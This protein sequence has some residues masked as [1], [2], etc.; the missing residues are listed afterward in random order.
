MEGGAIATDTPTAEILEY[1]AE[2]PPQTGHGALQYARALKATGGAEE[3]AKGQVI[4]A[5]ISM[6]LSTSEEAAFKSDWRTTIR[7]HHWDRLDMLLWRG[8]AKQ[9]ARMVPLV[10]GADHQKLAEARIGL[11]RKANG[12]DA[13]IAKVPATLKDDPGLAMSA[14][15]GVLQGG[16]Q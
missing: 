15:Y 7:D 1:F 14:S 8:E 12:V 6:S 16:A 3:E 9:A 13:L 5:W 11:R 10:G 4:L 2:Q